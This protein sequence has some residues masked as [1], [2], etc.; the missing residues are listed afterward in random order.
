MDVKVNH[1]HSLK[2][3]DRP[4]REEAEAA[5]RTLLAWAGDNPEREGLQDTPRRVTEAFTEYFAGYRQNPAEALERTFSETGGYDDI[6][7][8]RD[9]PFTSHCEHHMAPFYGVAHVA[10]LPNASIVGISKIARVVEG[11]ARRLQTQEM[12][13]SQI[14][15]CMHDSLDGRGVAVMM[16]AVHSCMSSRG[17]RKPGVATITTLFLGEFKTNPMMQARFMEQVRMRGGPQF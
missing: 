14:A 6:V 4:S 9:I 10:Y 15:N 1:K 12:L 16:E 7:M 5:V 2:P 11:F 3:V 8:L 17:V 13:T